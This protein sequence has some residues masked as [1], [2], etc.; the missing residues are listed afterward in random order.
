MAPCTVLVSCYLMFGIYM[1]ISVASMEWCF[2]LNR[3]LHFNNWS[4]MLLIYSNKYYQLAELYDL[5]CNRTE[6]YFW[7]KASFKS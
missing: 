7:V 6:V 4:N 5:L 1:E 3:C 2:Y